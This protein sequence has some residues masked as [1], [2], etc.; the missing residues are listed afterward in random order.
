MS[1]SDI[2]FDERGMVYPD[3]RKHRDGTPLAAYLAEA[4][5]LMDDALSGGVDA[6]LGAP[7]TTDDFEHLRW[8]PY[9][10]DLPMT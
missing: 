5:V 2:S 10:A 9:P 4:E 3:H 6:P 1:L 8:F 7:T